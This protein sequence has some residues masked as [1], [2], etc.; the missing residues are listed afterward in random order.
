MRPFPYLE[1]KALTQRLGVT[2]FQHHREE[3]PVIFKHQ[4]M[5]YFSTAV[6]EDSSLVC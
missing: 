1:P 2:D 3:A 5:D 4:Y 6:S